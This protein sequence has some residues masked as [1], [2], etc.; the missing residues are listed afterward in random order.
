MLVYLYFESYYKLCSVLKLFESIIVIPPHT[1]RHPS[2]VNY[3]LNE[4]VVSE[5]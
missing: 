1:C 4:I 2:C 5:I 3:E